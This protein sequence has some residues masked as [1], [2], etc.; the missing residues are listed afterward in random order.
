MTS[1][2]FSL[3]CEESSIPIKQFCYI[4]EKKTMNYEFQHISVLVVYKVSVSTTQLCHQQKQIQPAGE[5]VSIA[6]FQQNLFGKSI[7]G[8]PGGISGKE[9]ACQCRRYKRCG[10]DPWVGKIP[11]RMKCQPTP[12]FLPG[13][14]H[15][16]WSLAEYTVHWVAKRW[17]RLKQ[18][19]MQAHRWEDGSGL[20]LQG[21][22]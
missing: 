2:S 1:V 18:L 17:T 9:P 4:L 16:Q 15:G 6:A 20:N 22:P 5:Q 11:Q 8:F 12:V 13:E 21:A 7:G 10:L 14:S 19:S 3:L